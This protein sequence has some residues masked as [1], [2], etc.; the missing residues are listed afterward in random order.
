[1]RE[2]FSKTCFRVVTVAAFL[3][4]IAGI[5]NS[6]RADWNPG[7]PYKMHYP[8]LPDPFGWDVN[9]TQPKVL[10]D[11]WLCTETGPVSDVHL[12]FSSHQ[13]MPF[14]IFS[15]HLSIHADLPAGSGGVPYSMPGPTLWVA[16]I[17]A[18]LF[19]V[20]LW[21]TGEQGWYDPP[22]FVL[23]GD[24]LLIWQLNIQHIPNPFIQEQ[25][26]VYWLDVSI[27]SDAMLGWKTSLEHFNDDAV[28]GY[29][30]GE[31]WQELRDPFTG[32]SL[33]LAFVITV[34]EP[35]TIVLVGIALA[36]LPAVIRRK[37][38]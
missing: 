23:P 22:S 30:P 7:D 10:A 31:P 35:G 12:W 13:D 21:G 27:L 6:A 33:D 37:Q 15:V 2:S 29:L 14:N 5:T 4:A 34:P 9:F 11:D 20:R 3:L 38:T 25:G 18:P 19:S 8:Q 26:Q 32:Q 17:P 24:H 28:W 36:G 1:M 16:D